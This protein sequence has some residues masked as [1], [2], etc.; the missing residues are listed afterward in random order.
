[1]TSTELGEMKAVGVPG[2]ER[3]SSHDIILGGG[4]LSRAVILF[5]FATTFFA[6]TSWVDACTS[7]ANWKGE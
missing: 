4:S 3:A 1:M 6:L 7:V 5:N 2:I